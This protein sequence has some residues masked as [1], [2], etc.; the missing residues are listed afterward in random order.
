MCYLVR[1]V[2]PPNGTVLDPFAGSG[3]TGKACV[4][5]N[6]NYILIELEKDSCLIAEARIKHAQNKSSVKKQIR[7]D[8]I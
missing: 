1:L 8:G 7:I 6:F 3:S 5:E 4:L 2:T